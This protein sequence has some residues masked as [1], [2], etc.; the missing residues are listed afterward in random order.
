MIG[1]DHMSHVHPYFHILPKF[2]SHSLHFSYIPI[3]SSLTP[4]MHAHVGLVVAEY[5]RGGWI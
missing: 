1:K 3:K 5:H 2:S 4:N